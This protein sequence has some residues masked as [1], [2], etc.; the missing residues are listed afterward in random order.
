MKLLTFVILIGVEVED[1]L[2]E[3]I[4]EHG[5]VALHQQVDQ[6]EL[7]WKQK[8][9]NGHLS[10][11]SSTRFPSKEKENHIFHIFSWDCSMYVLLVF[12]FWSKF[13]F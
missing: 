10:E 11:N 13:C 4:E 1:A 8:S 6:A 12:N 9:H 7:R 2:D 3:V 5:G